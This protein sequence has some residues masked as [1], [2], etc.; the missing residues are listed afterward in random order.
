MTKVA[1]R[2]FRWYTAPLLRHSVDW[3]IICTL[4]ADDAIRTPIPAVWLQGGAHYWQTTDWSSPRLSALELRQRLFTQVVSSNWPVCRCSH[5]SPQMSSSESFLTVPHSSSL[6][7]GLTPRCLA[8]KFSSGTIHQRRACRASPVSLYRRAVSRHS[9]ERSGWLAECTWR[10]ENADGAGSGVGFIY[11][12]AEK[13]EMLQRGMHEIVL[14][15]KIW[16]QGSPLPTNIAP[17]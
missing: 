13:L 7:C 12:S 11:S 9:T 4:Y 3:Q 5:Q 8:V 15:E 1:K 6:R 17:F 14:A 2:Q 16:G 10:G